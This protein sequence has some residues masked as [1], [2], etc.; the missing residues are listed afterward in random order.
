MRI[1]IVGLGAIGGSIGVRWRQRHDLS[2]LARG[3]VLESLNADAWRL[4]LHDA[5]LWAK[6]AASGSAVLLGQQDVV[7]I[8]V[9]GPPA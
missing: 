7:V 5:N 3:K 4:D 8:P 9:E 2:L 1:G 6:V